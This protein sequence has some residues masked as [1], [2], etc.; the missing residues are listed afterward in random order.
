M[1][2]KKTII[3]LSVV[4]G[5]LLAIY[6]CLSF[7]FTSH[8]YFRT[9]INGINVSG[10]SV[11]GV[12]KTFQKN[13]DTYE[14]LITE[15]DATTETIVGKDFDLQIEWKQELEELLEKQ[16]GFDWIGKLFQPDLHEANLNICYDAVKLNEILKALPCMESKKQIAPVNAGISDYI[17]AKGY[18]LI[19]AVLGSQMD[20]HIFYKNVENCLYEM[21][22]QLNL[23]EAQCY[24]QPE[25]GDDNEK[26]LA[27]IEQLNTALKAVITYQVGDE[28]QVLDASVFQ[29]WL[30]YNADF[31]VSLDEEQLSTYV[32]E[33]SATYNTYGKAKKLMTSYGVEVTITRSQ[34]GWKVDSAAEK[35]AIRINIMAGEQIT[36]DLEYFITAHSRGKNDYGNS[37]VEI[38]LTAQHLFLYVDGALVLESDFVSGNLSKG[39]DTPTGAY[40]LTYKT[41]NATLRGEDYATFVNYWMPYAGNVGMHDATWRNEFGGNIYETNGS[42]GCIN[43]P[44]SSAKIIYEH[45]Y[46]GFPVLVYT[47]PGTEPVTAPAPEIPIGQ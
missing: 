19:P 28:T 27:A 43:L 15:R 9:T 30:T 4:I 36:R 44:I 20:Y 7:Y 11:A 40:G 24:V 12:K 47:L 1:T 25:I 34:Y 26:L 46:D 3:I 21:K 31:V 45:I 35:E 33:L 10:Q 22:E 38:N 16:N 17:P 6:L 42:H 39:Y 2:Q 5:G 32:K 41:R 18:E 23:H 37:Y 8:F 14:L 13:T 29:P